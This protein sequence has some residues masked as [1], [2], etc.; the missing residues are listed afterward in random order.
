MDAGFICESGKHVRSTLAISVIY[1]MRL[2][3]EALATKQ[4][5]RERISTSICGKR[6][7]EDSTIDVKTVVGVTGDP[8]TEFRRAS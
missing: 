4:S 5:N 3:R 2:R 1:A 6:D 8:K 7:K